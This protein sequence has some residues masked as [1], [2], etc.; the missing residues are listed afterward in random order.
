LSSTCW[1]A[2][3]TGGRPTPPATISTSRPFA[4]ST[5]HEVPNG[6]RTPI[7]APGR[8]A[9]SARVTGPTARIV[10]TSG[11]PLTEIGTSPTPKA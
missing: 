9:H 8:V 7:T 4:S 11:E 3:R 10:W 6:P 5:G 1:S 2:G